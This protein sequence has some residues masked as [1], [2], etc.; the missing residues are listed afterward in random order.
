VC[1][2]FD[3]GEDD[4]TIF[5]SMEFVAGEDL[6]A[7]IRRTGRL[8]SERVVEIA[9]QLCAGLAAAHAEGVLHRDLKPA[10]ILISTDA[11]SQQQQVKVLDFGVARQADDDPT[12]GGDGKH[13]T[14][15]ITFHGH[16]VGTLGYMSPEQFSATGDADIRSDVYSLGAILH[17]LLSDQL[18]IDV[19][20]CT[21][22][23]AARR[24]TERPP[25]WL[26]SLDSSLRGDVETI[27]FKA[28]E[29]EPSRRYQSPAELAR[30]LR[31]YLA[32]EP[33]EARRDSVMYVL[34][35]QAARYRAL[36]AGATLF[37][38]IAIGF[39]FYAR[40]QEHQQQ[41]V[42]EV[43]I[44][45]QA[46]AE[47]AR[48]RADLTAASL[49]EELSASRIAEGRLLGNSGDL[50]NAER[51]LWDELLHAKNKD[52]ARWAVW[53]LYSRSGCANTILAHGGECQDVSLSPDG[54]TFATIGE[55]RFVRIWNLRDGSN[56][57][58][59]EHGVRSGRSV[60]FMRDGAE[61]IVTGIDGAA[62]IDVATGVR[63][64][65]AEVRDAYGVDVS[66]DG[67]LIAIAT[68]DGAVH[69]FDRASAQQLLLVQRNEVV[70]QRRR[71]ARGVCF[72]SAAK[73]LAV[74]YDDG[75]V[76]L[77]NLSMDGGHP[78]VSAGPEIAGHP[79][80]G[81][82]CVRFSPDDQTLVSGGTDRSVRWWRVSDGGLI[83]ETPTMNGTARGIAFSADGA[84]IAV[85]GYWKT[86]F[87]DARTGQPLPPPGN[88]LSLGAGGSYAVA[89]TP[90]GNQLL[91]AQDDG[92]CRIWKLT[93]G[94]YA[95]LP[96]TRATVRDLA[97]VRAGD[98]CVLATA[99][100]DGTVRVRAAPIADPLHT[101]WRDLMR[102]DVGDR[103]RSM[104]MTPDASLLM[105]GRAD[106]HVVTLDARDG[107]VVQDVE[108]HRGTVNTIRTTPD[109]RLMITCGTDARIHIWRRRDDGAGWESAN[110]LECEGDVVG[111]AINR[112]GNMLV[113]T[114]R[115]THLRFWSLD[116]N[117]SAS[118]VK[119]VE[120]SFTMWKPSFNRA[121][122]QLAV[123]AWDRS[124]M[125][126]D[127]Y[128]LQRAVAETTQPTSS[129]TT[130]PSSVS[131]PQHVLSLMGHT[132]L[133]VALAFD[134]TGRLLASGSNDGTLRL[135]DV[136]ETSALTENEVDAS[137]ATIDRRRGLA[138]L[139]AQAGDSMCVAFIPAK[140]RIPV[141]GPRAQVGQS[142]VAVG[143][144]D[145]KVRLWDLQYFHESIIY[146]ER[147]QRRLRGL[148]STSN[149]RPTSGAST[150]PAR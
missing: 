57:A 28:L 141:S 149:S 8:S 116:S 23:E 133:P 112:A 148:P 127:T 73:H 31:H 46:E 18:P 131:S 25:K 122:D 59:Y 78:S 44:D 19:A 106:G 93:G 53:E 108:A 101:T 63:R 62:L 3:V 140:P 16:L 109:G 36:A 64:A 14:T 29:K 119:H 1:R 67:A 33:I 66:R 85:G 97:I 132:Q 86:V 134:D 15:R 75:D 138:T 102:A 7:L 2:V 11:Q 144:T 80:G 103:L 13:A 99:Q 139:D 37:L 32:G 22:F 90:D 61:L 107:R 114:N 118:P 47:A 105:I 95:E 100:T 142:V 110:T 26:G 79:N 72:D 30:D 48:R 94:P 58:E 120:L 41:R 70:S 121:G 83:V 49:A 91:T 51:L 12:R 77:F 87:F 88:R 71:G 98:E 143:Y 24:V 129:P 39:V 35:K 27:V 69:L 135:W 6:A 96:S 40:D 42:A 130:A 68:N 81:A 60:T 10:N 65:F 4:E 5:F 117:G 76:R 150:A 123:G 104:A 50:V 55:D 146:N 128:A 115:P 34:R 45:A 54:K 126:W 136:S 17:Q 111:A 56:V 52:R 9:R 92:A 82:Q 124:I 89:F 20:N 74:A 21:I 137:G 145:G 125:L 113:T 147:Y 38:I 43:A 84:M